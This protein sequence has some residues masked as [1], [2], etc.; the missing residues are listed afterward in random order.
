MPSANWA[1]QTTTTTG[2]GALSLSSISGFPTVSQALGG[3]LN[4]YVPYAILD[5]ST[6][7]PYEEGYGY[8]GATNT[9]ERALIRATFASGTYTDVS[10]TA[11]S[12]PA[13]TK[14]LIVSFTA[15]AAG[16]VWVN[17]NRN[18]SASGRAAIASSHLSSH[19]ASS[20]GFTAVANRLYFA[21]FI[22]NV[23]ADVASL[24]VRCGTGV[25]STNIRLGI[26]ETGS[27]G[28]PGALLISTGALSTATSSTD[29]IGTVTQTRLQPGSYYS[30][31]VTD[32]APALGRLDGGG[33][34]F[35]PSGTAST[36]LLLPNVG[37]WASF[38]FGALPSTAP[39]T[40]FTTITGNASP[41][42]VF[43]VLA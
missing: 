27:D 38:T 3:L 19:S 20:T 6:G 22:L 7:A 30:A 12:L 10:P 33:Q 23:S 32:G 43:M 18:S 16:A 35:T 34:L 31:L 15:G 14:R 26:Y 5:D 25:A 37:F 17:A 24:G 39:T 21:P 40:G 41:A 4:K 13:G 8:L 1:Q 11:V 2:T 36:N 9:F 28:H 42:T 29:V